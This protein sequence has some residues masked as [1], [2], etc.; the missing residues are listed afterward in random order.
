MKLIF[1]LREFHGPNAWSNNSGWLIETLLDETKYSINSYSYL[2]WQEWIKFRFSNLQLH[3]DLNFAVKLACQIIS[4]FEI[5]EIPLTHDKHAE[6]KSRLFV[7]SQVH[8]LAGRAIKLSL[9]IVI[10]SI[11]GKSPEEY[12]DISKIDT[13]IRILI[14]R[15]QALHSHSLTNA[16]V[17]HAFQRGLPLRYLSENFNGCP[18]LQIG[19]GTCGR[20]LYSSSTEKDGLIGALV[21]KDKSM[22]NHTLLQLGYKTPN[23]AELPLSCTEKQL[24][25]ALSKIGYP[26]VLKPR[27]AEQGQGVTARIENQSS[28]I[29][30]L[31]KAK[32]AARSGLVLEQHVSGDYH[33][34]VVL[35]GQLVRVRQFKP[36]HLIADGYHSIRKTLEKA[37]NVDP[38]SVGVYCY[39][40]P[41]VIDQNMIQHLETQGF[42][43][44]SIPKLGTQVELLFDLINRDNWFELELI[45]QVDISLIR[46]SEDIAKA[47]GMD[48]IGID[49][50]SND[51][52]QP[53]YEQQ[54]IIIE[55]NAIQVLHPSA[56][57]SIL[58][59][60][61]PDHASSRIEVSVTV[62]AS[63][64]DWPKLNKTC[65]FL[66]NC[67]N[68]AIAIPIRL[69]DKIDK[70][71]IPML[72]KERPLIF[73]NDPKIVL[74]NRSVEALFFL[75]DWQEFIHSGLPTT[76]IDHLNLLGK[77]E[78]SLANRW[79][80]LM[81]LV[82]VEKCNRYL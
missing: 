29:K 23:Q 69:R 12:K 46:M 36:P 63:E 18:I 79:D 21:C 35:N 8:D 7:K 56:S 17:D 10:Q 13:A 50:L 73:Y 27:D 44:D 47:F 16:L 33:R 72:S 60:M 68:H 38:E 54:P 53:V 4:P 32:E 24:L 9:N 49:V 6:K 61:F 70:S 71:L 59:S 31:N 45:N 67:G 42:G 55:L 76:Q 34:L 28:L 66:A 3:A 2:K 77:P 52:T 20:L 41:P 22:A 11:K 51:I 30:A 74:F 39:G 57:V 48:N 58:K 1:G 78:A 15:T 62:C 65:T 75:I 81:R 80:E 19:T 37:N 26:C 82:P 64:N 5:H 14:N 40:K 43:L 25:S